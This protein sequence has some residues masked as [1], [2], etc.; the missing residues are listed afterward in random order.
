M[1]FINDARML[2]ENEAFSGIIVALI[3]ENKSVDRNSFSFSLSNSNLYS[4]ERQG[5][6]RFSNTPWNNN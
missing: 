1:Q 4:L 5:G 2:R 6:S 3:K